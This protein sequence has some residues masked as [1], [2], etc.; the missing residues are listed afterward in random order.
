MNF[1]PQKL[2]DFFHYKLIKLIALMCAIIGL[3][4]LIILTARAIYLEKTLVPKYQVKLEKKINEQIE[5][6]NDFLN[7]HQENALLL[8]Q[9]KKILAY[10]KNKQLDNTEFR[11]YILKKQENFKF[12]NLLIIDDNSQVLFTTTP[13]Y[14]HLNLL[15]ETLTKA[16][17]RR[18]YFASSMTL[19]RDF[20]DFLFSTI[21]KEP[22]FFITYPLLDQQKFVGALAYQINED[23]LTAISRNY[24]DLGNTGEIVMAVQTA[25][26]AFFI[27]P[28]R[29]DPEIRFTKRKL[30]EKG[31]TSITLRATRGERGSGIATDYLGN[32]VL[33]TWAFIPRVDWGIVVKINLE[34]IR[35]PIE[36]YH[37]YIIISAIITAV[38]ILLNLLI[39]HRQITRKLREKFP[40]FIRQIYHAS[41]LLL[42]LLG[43][44]IYLLLISIISFKKDYKK[45]IKESQAVA[46]NDVKQGVDEIEQY[47]E[48]IQRLGDFIA[49]D[50][51]TERLISEDIKRR[52][53]REIIETDGIASITI[54]Y[55]PYQ[56]DKNKKLFAPS[57]I[58]LRDGS[59]QERM[60]DHDYDYSNKEEGIIKTAW[61]IKAFESKKAQWMNPTIEPYSQQKVIVYAIPFFHNNDETPA[62]VVAIAYKVSEFSEVARKIAIGPS[63]FTHIISDDG[64]F[65]YHPLR[66]NIEHKKTLFQF[67]QEEGD[68]ELARIAKEIEKGKPILVNF[69]NKT[70]LSN[71]W[72]YTHPVPL[73]GWTVVT[74]FKNSEIGMSGVKTRH[75]V[76]A[77]VTYSLIVLLLILAILCCFF[78]RDFMSYLAY[79]NLIL[80][81]TI[82]TL[83][84]I[85]AQT[86][87]MVAKGNIRVSDASGV[88]KFINQQSEEAERK[89]EPLP[90]A[91]PAGIEIYSLEETSPRQITFSGYIWHR[92]HKEIHKNIK[93]A[94]RIPQA[95][96]FSIQREIITTENDWDVVAMDVNVTLYQEHDYTFYPFDIQRYVISLEHADLTQNTI[97]VPDVEGYIDLNPT[98]L[99]GIN[100]TFSDMIA[101]TKKTFFDFVP[102]KPDSDLGVRSYRQRSE[103]YRLGYNIIMVDDVLGPA[104]SFFLPLLVILISIFAVLMLEQRKTDPYTIIGPFTG[105]FFALVLLHKSLNESAPSTQI[106]YIEYAFFFTYITIIILVSHTILLQI[107]NDDD[108]YQ[109]TVVRFLKNAF[110][111][112]QLMAWIITTL[113][114]FY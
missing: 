25:T 77:I 84:F 96:N 99:P 103:Q 73:T 106:L 89:N 22:A 58:Q 2:D 101:T 7:R 26:D 93:K 18:S 16:P 27:T 90:I 5:I 88:R 97:V 109:N 71:A 114:I 51:R 29:L 83:W 66:R 79:S 65:I 15:D 67:A 59:L 60:I 50:L 87:D 35:A 82:I 3:L 102:Y 64:T 85:I 28:T 111:P 53:K 21:L 100:T 61:F 49:Q 47:V 40:E 12:E 92:Y 75:H 112:C 44:F 52:L 8:A 17:L 105:L 86:P 57:I 72:M 24:L 80:V 33:A 46:I 36:Q 6:I 68:D 104:I 4:I 48:K 108:F 32:K 55:A 91:V 76:F 43:I 30:F 19:T 81:A 9:D 37:N 1:S 62:G 23:E 11:N 78:K 31:A 63:G 42:I 107:Y 45:S 41:Y 54:A 56:Y 70:T 74:V 10:N 113:L 14:A 34:E 38:F 13:K 95:I 110:W 69:E 39:Y 20:S 98:K 94:I